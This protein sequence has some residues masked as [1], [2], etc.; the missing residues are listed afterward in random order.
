MVSEIEKISDVNACDESL[1]SI[2][3]VLANAMNDPK[4]N[5]DIRSVNL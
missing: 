2:H 1:L 5:R 4:Y 3:S